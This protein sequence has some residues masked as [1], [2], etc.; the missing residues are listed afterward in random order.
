MDAKV[1]FGGRLDL[2]IYK[3]TEIDIITEVVNEDGTAHDLSEFNDI[4]IQVFEKIHGTLLYEYLMSE[5]P[6]V[7][8]SPANYVS[9]NVPGGI[10]IRPKY[11]YHEC[12]GIGASP[13]T[14]TLIYH[15]VLT[16]I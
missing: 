1:I 4:L 16:I 14:D 9:W 15:G 13:E 3:G 6:E 8:N 2:Q 11:Y 5:G 7:M 12:A 10:D